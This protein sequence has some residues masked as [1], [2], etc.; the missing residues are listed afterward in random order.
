MENLEQFYIETIYPDD[1]ETASREDLKIARDLIRGIFSRHEYSTS[2]LEYFDNSYPET[3]DGDSLRKFLEHPS[4]GI[5]YLARKT[6]NEEIIGVLGIEP[7]IGSIE[8]NNVYLDRLHLAWARTIERYE[9]RGIQ[10]ALFNEFFNDAHRIAATQTKDGMISLTVNLHRQNSLGRLQ[11]A[12]KEF[13]FEDAKNIDS[14]NKNPLYKDL[15]N[16]SRM[17]VAETA[18]DEN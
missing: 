4:Y 16:M 2:H 9:G 17:L 6:T 12:L 8:E 13:G 14:P 15:H 18:S 1:A 11:A 10:H 5:L 7:F 3:K